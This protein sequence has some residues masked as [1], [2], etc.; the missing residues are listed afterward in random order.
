MNEIVYFINVE[1]LF[2]STLFSTNDFKNAIIEQTS[3]ATFRKIQL[4]FDKIL[5]LEERLISLN[6]IQTKSIKDETEFANVRKEISS[7]FINTQNLI[8]KDFFDSNYEKIV[9]L[10]QLD[11]YRRKLSNCKTFIGTV[12]NYTFF[13]NYYLE[14]MNKLEHKSNILENGGFETALETPAQSL[15]AIFDKIKK[16]LSRYTKFI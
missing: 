10:E 11:N 15:L 2:K 13:E 4:A 12:D 5:K 7:T 8:I 14:Q 16:L 6:S 1:T 3:K 9:N